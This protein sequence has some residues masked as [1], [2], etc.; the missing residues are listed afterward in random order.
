MAL[1]AC[2][3]TAQ[4]A[5]RSL[6][7]FGFGLKS[8]PYKEFSQLAAE[9]PPRETPQSKSEILKAPQALGLEQRK[10]PRG[11]QSRYFFHQVNVAA[12]QILI[13]WSVGKTL[14]D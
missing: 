6:G 5:L 10:P 4:A 9:Q 3:G 14:K 1:H 7:I 2:A 13:C 8:R 11:D 12:Q